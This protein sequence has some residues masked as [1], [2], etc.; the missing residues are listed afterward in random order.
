MKRL[1]DGGP[2]FHCDKEHGVDTTSLH[3]Q[4]GG[5][6]EFVDDREVSVH[7]LVCWPGKKIF[8]SLFSESFIQTLQPVVC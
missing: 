8:L 4:I 3:D 5:I 2:S 1:A 6:D 7:E